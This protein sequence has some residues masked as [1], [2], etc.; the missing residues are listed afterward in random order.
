MEDV[1]CN[2]AREREEVGERGPNLTDLG[3]GEAGGEREAVDGGVR[4]S[5]VRWPFSYVSAYSK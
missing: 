4:D 5:G 2:L 3:G 1:W